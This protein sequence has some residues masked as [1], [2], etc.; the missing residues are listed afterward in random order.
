MFSFIHN[1][2]GIR[3]LRVVFLLH[4]SKSFPEIKIT[5]LFKKLEA[6]LNFNYQAE[7][8]I[9]FLMDGGLNEVLLLKSQLDSYLHSD[10]FGSCVNKGYVA[11][12]LRYL[13]DFNWGKDGIGINYHRIWFFTADCLQ[14]DKRTR[15]HLINITGECQM[16]LVHYRCYEI[17]RELEVIGLCN[18]VILNC[19][20]FST[21]C[22]LLTISQGNFSPFHLFLKVK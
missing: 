13:E 3:Q 15:H 6:F 22:A 19:A 5:A 18:G 9:K 14:L 7:S 12:V 1:P 21:K 16:N 10:V 8:C 11:P 17:T 2:A 20:F 4:K